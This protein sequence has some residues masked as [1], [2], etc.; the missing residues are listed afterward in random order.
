[1]WAIEVVYADEHADVTLTSRV[2]VTPSP[3]G[4]WTLTGPV[5]EIH[6]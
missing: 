6:H 4:E 1:M 5:R 2:N 3:G